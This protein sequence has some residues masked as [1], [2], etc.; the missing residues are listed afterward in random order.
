LSATAA[1]SRR[2]CR[3]PPAC[4]RSTRAPAASA[5]ISALWTGSSLPSPTCAG[6]LEP[7]STLAD[8]RRQFKDLGDTGAY[9]FLWVVGEP[10]PSYDEW[11]ASRGRS[12]HGAT[13]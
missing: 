11:C 9:Y 13:P 12:H 6:R 4:S 7:E 1:R 2:S 5:P 10:V 3:T 8:L